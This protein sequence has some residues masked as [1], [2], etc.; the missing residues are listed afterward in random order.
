MEYEVIPKEDGKYYPTAFYCENFITIPNLQSN[1]GILV[2]QELVYI[3]DY[4]IVCKDNNKIVGYNSLTD[5]GDNLF[6]GQICV[7]EDYRRKGIGSKLIEQAIM[8]EQDAKKIG[9]TV[10]MSNIP[11]QRTF[12]KMGFSKTP[13][14]TGWYLFTKELKKKKTMCKR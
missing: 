8:L 14:S 11:S 1:G 12:E 13:Y 4:L 10:L 3:G 6:I 7:L 2:A 9:A 5:N